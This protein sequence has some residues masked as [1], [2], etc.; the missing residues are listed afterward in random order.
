MSILNKKTFY[1]YILHDCNKNHSSDDYEFD[2]L[3]TVRNAM[4]MKNG[5]F[6]QLANDVKEMVECRTEKFLLGNGID[7]RNLQ[8]TGEIKEI[9]EESYN[10][11][12]EDDK[13]IMANMSDKTKKL[14]LGFGFDLDG[15]HR[16]FKVEAKN[17]IY[18]KSVLKRKLGYSPK[19]IFK[20]E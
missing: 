13:R 12:V 5:F 18:L 8:F 6:L 19:I 3:K 9:S 4:E 1:F 15:W 10:L 7:V 16:P 17:K 2:Y 14:L 20:N 11:I